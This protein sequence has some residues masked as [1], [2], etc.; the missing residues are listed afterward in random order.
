MRRRSCAAH[1]DRCARNG[2]ERPDLPNAIPSSNARGARIRAR[3]RRPRS[4]ARSSPPRIARS[5]A[6]RRR[7]RRAQAT[8][9]QRWW[10]PLAAAAAIGVVAIGI[11]QLMPKDSLVAPNE[12]VAAVA[13]GGA[14]EKLPAAPASTSVNDALK[15]R[16]A[17]AQAARPADAEIAPKKK[18][19]AMATAPVA[20]PVPATEPLRAPTA[21]PGPAV[22]PPAAP[23]PAERPNPRRAAVAPAMMQAHPNATSRPAPASSRRAHPHPSRPSHSPPPRKSARMRSPKRSA[24]LRRAAAGVVAGTGPGAGSGVGGSAGT[25]AVAAKVPAPPP[26]AQTP[27]APFADGAVASRKD[28][29]ASGSNSRRRT[30]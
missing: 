7:R 15:E 3:R 9:P 12:R 26:S 6:V 11:V 5:T 24:T 18:Q 25:N 10:M 16:D 19:E 1:W 8:R 30:R 17:R 20:T 4:T 27:P 29:R 21:A 23:A 14:E 22:A 28:A 2:H 13:R